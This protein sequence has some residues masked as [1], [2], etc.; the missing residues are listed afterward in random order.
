[1]SFT[2]ALLRFLIV[3][4][5]AFESVSD[6]LPLRFLHLPI[7][8]LATSAATALA[9]LLWI[10][11]VVKRQR[12]IGLFR[13]FVIFFVYCLV[14]LTRGGTLAGF[15]LDYLRLFG[16]LAV[17][18]V[19]AELGAANRF[20][21]WTKS[22]V[23]ATIVPIGFGL[24]QMLFNAGLL[25][26]SGEFNRVYGTFRHPSDYGYFL[27]IIMINLV[28]FWF[29]Y[30]KTKRKLLFLLLFSF[31]GIQLLFTFS[32]LPWMVFILIMM[33]LAFLWKR[34]IERFL[35]PIL[36]VF[37]VLTILF[38]DLLVKRFS[39]EIGQGVHDPETEL[40]GMDLT[41]S[42]VSRLLFA[43]TA[44]DEFLKYPLVGRGLGYFY[45]DLSPRF[46]GFSVEAHSDV[47]ELLCETGLL[48][49]AV[50]S[51]GLIGLFLFMFRVYSFA[52]DPLIR[53]LALIGSMMVIMEALQMT[54]DA[55]LRLA[56][57]EFYWWVYMGILIGT[58]RREVRRTAYVH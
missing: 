27:V 49:T 14:G 22:L 2:G 43:S 12:I 4:R 25:Q 46:F 3:F 34:R 50:F 13:P 11:V 58:I 36:F 19:G 30:F 35:I 54:F 38:G 48:G 51:Y 9:I 17:M 6:S 7:E 47:A 55:A 26:F 1:M 37:L 29:I 5:G 23:L 52:S 31:L 32:R 45:Y 20:G 21:S 40:M 28:V 16:Y 44:I 24:Y 8:N 10:R 56:D 18:W 57:L 15:L 39:A 41:G 33:I 53:S 42:P